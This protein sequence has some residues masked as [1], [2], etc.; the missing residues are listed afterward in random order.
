VHKFKDQSG[1]MV[2]KVFVANVH[3]QIQWLKRSPLLS[4]QLESGKLKIVGVRYDLDTGG[5]GIII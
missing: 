3:D 4:E 1:D 2:D 5:V